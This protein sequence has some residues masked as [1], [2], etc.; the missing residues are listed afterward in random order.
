MKLVVRRNDV[1]QHGAAQTNCRT[2]GGGLLNHYFGDSIVKAVTS[3]YP[4]HD[5]LRWRFHGTPGSFWDDLENQ[6]AFFDW[7]G[8]RAGVTTLSDWYT[9]TKRSF[10]EHAKDVSLL[11]KRY[12]DSLRLAL[13]Q[14]YPEHHW[15]VWQFPQVPSA[16]WDSRDNR[17][18]FLIWAMAQLRP[19][20]PP[21]N[22]PS[23]LHL[24]Y[25]VS[26]NEYRKKFGAK[27]IDSEFSGCLASAVMA[28]F[29]E[30][31][32]LPWKFSTTPKGFWTE[33]K[34]R[35]H[36][37]EWLSMRVL[38]S[39]K[40]EDW[41]DVP[42]TLVVDNGGAALLSGFYSDSLAEALIDNFPEH[43]W[44]PWRFDRAPRGFWKQQAEARK[45]E[46]IRSFLDK[47][48]KELKVHQ[49]D[50]W[51]RI[52]LKQQRSAGILHVVASF[53]GLSGALR[54]AYPEHAWLASKFGVIGKKSRQKELLD[55]LSQLFPGLDIVE[56]YLVDDL[57]A[58][59]E[60]SGLQTNRKKTGYKLDAFIPRAR[61]GFEYDGEQHFQDRG[62]LRISPSRMRDRD[63]K[64]RAI[65]ASLGIRII[66]V[67][68]TWNGQRE[69]LRALIND[70][71]PRED[72]SPGI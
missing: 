67:D 6:R 26:P 17:K 40:L 50:D 25:A 24:W 14:I 12:G 49:P 60:R 30:H 43:R 18:Q 61:L 46:A 47:M 68:F 69:S 70:P 8:R 72:R 45:P 52:S 71:L 33:K 57:G 20:V 62:G 10:Y 55:C 2:A 65:S 16:Y 59:S 53:G 38:K 32:W 36:F 34:N 11:N 29:P 58:S 48:A 23:T 4:E 41:Y 3:V 7:V 5:W 56:E 35:R 39:S 64:K 19:Q 37:F 31:E 63:E 51:Y 42:A 22:S 1:T 13:E 21:E 28:T 44:E 27:L 15:L 66:T 9:M 54:L